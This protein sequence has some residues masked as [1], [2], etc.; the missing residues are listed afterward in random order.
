MTSKNI[1]IDAV[2]S[3]FSISQLSTHTP[4]S[5]SSLLD[6]GNKLEKFTTIQRSTTLYKKTDFNKHR[7]RVVSNELLWQ[8]RQAERIG[9]NIPLFTNHLHPNS[10]PTLK[11]LISQQ[12]AARNLIPPPTPL[13]TPLSSP[14]PT[15]LS[16]PP[17]SIPQSRLCLRNS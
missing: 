9:K 5:A 8:I 3:P 15:L 4:K 10:L 16:L 17:F 13:P 1:V 14:H 11:Y 12:F 2:S 7:K 6:P